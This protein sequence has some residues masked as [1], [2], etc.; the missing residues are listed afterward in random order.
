MRASVWYVTIGLVG[1][2]AGALW[3]W[4]PVASLVAL[5]LVHIGVWLTAGM[6]RD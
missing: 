1:F 4:S 6:V 3:A 2:A 5:A